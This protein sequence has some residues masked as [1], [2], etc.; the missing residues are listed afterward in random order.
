MALL[1][2]AAI[3]LSTAACKINPT[4]PDRYALVYGVSDYSAANFSNLGSTIDDAE[5]V[6]QLLMNKGYTVFLRTD[7]GSSGPQI[8]SAS[9][10]QFKTDMSTIAQNLEKDDLLVFYFS[11]HGAQ[12]GFLP[13][14]GDEDQFSEQ[15]DEYIAFYPTSTDYNS[16]IMSDTDF[17]SYIKQ[18]KANKK[19][20]LLDSCNSGGFIGQEYSFDSTSSDYV[21]TDKKK[22]NILSSTLNSFFNPKTGD[23]P[24]SDAIVISAAG[25]SEY[26]WESGGHGFLTHGILNAVRLGDYDKNGYLDTG[27]LYRY[28]KSFIESHWNDLWKNTDFIYDSD[29]NKVYRNGLQFMPHISGG[30]VDYVLFEAD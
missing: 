2:A 16:F 20:I 5:S 6:A 17:Y 7:D 1:I 14:S 19:V 3:L 15:N 21:N 28:T 23:V 8:E 9:L 11:G 18:S 10:S 22:D 24:A 4:P 25:E 27:E 13:Y 12:G 29:G 30:P 26:S